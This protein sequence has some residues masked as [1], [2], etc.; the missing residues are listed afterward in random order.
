MSSVSTVI[1]QRD[2]LGTD[3][4]TRVREALECDPPDPSRLHAL[5][6]EAGV[7]GKPEDALELLSRAA[8]LCPDNA[9]YCLSIGRL[10][11]AETMFNQAALAYLRAQE[12]APNDVTI[13]TELAIVLRQLHKHEEAKAVTAHASELTSAKALLATKT[14]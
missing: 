11:A 8:D 14:P 4:D 5:G 6:L 2:S 1:D 10:L 9:V 7:A 13:L 3:F 12:L